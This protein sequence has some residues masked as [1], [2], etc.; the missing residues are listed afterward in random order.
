MPGSG[1]SAAINGKRRFANRPTDPEWA[2]SLEPGW[3]TRRMENFNNLVT[4]IPEPEDLV[5]DGWTD[6][7]GKLLIMVR[8]EEQ[9]ALTPE[10]LMSTMEL[11]D[12]EKMEQIRGRVED[13]L[14]Q[15]EAI[16]L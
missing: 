8:N 5:N 2:A 12:F 6:I 10:Y 4:G 3:Q 15:L 1:A 16:G 7:I 13:M 14:K 9:A 11:A